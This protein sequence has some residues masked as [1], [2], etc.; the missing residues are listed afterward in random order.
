GGGTADQSVLAVSAHGGREKHLRRWRAGRKQHPPDPARAAPASV[1]ATA[2]HHLSRLRGRKP[3]GGRTGGRGD[4][5]DGGPPD[6]DRACPAPAR[7]GL[8]MLSAGGGGGGR[9]DAGALA[10]TALCPPPPRCIDEAD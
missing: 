4:R 10:G 2:W 7:S 1:P 3:R 9:A 5:Q 6:I 8:D